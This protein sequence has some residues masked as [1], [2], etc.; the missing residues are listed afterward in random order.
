[1]R[2]VEVVKYDINWKNKFNIEKNILLKIF[3]KNIIKIYHIGS[4][5]I[6][7]L[8]SKPIIDILIEVKDLLKIDEKND[9]MIK[10]GYEPLGEY[11][12]KN[13]RFFQ[14]GNNN[15]THHVHI[16]QKK[17][18][19]IVRHLAFRD[20]LKYNHKRLKKY[21]DLKIKLAKQFQNDIE[22]YCNGKDNFIKETEKEALLWYKRLW[23]N[24]T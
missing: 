18:Y 4:T 17:D 3:N 7:G 12:I 23:R 14:K 10:A 6:K 24:W 11:G 15:R 21:E 19:N 22:S 13:R 16:F 8:S 5:S 20:Y 9:E 1:M 2:K